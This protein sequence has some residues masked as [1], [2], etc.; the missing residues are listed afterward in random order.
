MKSP[1]VLW[2]RTRSGACE[3]C[4]FSYIPESGYSPRAFL[5]VVI[6]PNTPRGS[7]KHV[8]PARASFDVGMLIIFESFQSFSVA[9]FVFGAR[10]GMISVYSPNV[11]CETE[12]VR[13][14]EGGSVECQTSCLLGKKFV[15]ILSPGDWLG[16]QVLGERAALE[17]SELISGGYL[18][19][20]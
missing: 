20:C 6:P 14:V 4:R 11:A 16:E 15:E 1:L 17:K 7:W 8:Q 2:L 18:Q 9:F 3:R 19:V 10:V 13:C 12:A 5:Q